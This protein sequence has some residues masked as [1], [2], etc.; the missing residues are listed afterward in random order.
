MLLLGILCTTQQAF[1]QGT[2]T[3]TG[4][5]KNSKSKETIA[6]VSVMVKGTNDGTFTDDKGNFKLLTLAKPPFTLIISSVGFANKEINVDAAGGAINVE[7]DASFSLG[8]DIVVAASRLPERILEAPVSIERVTSTQIRNIPGAGY[9][10]ALNNLKGVDVVTSSYTFK[11]VSTRGFN[12]SGNLRFN[13]FVDGMDNTAPA[14]NFSVS[15]IVGLT[16]LDVD[17][18]ELLS[19]PSSALYGSGGQNGTLLISSKDPFKYQGVSFMVKQ[20]VM[21]LGND[22][23]NDATLFQD[24]VLRWG[25]KIGD[26]FA[27]K[28]GAEFMKTDDWVADDRSNLARNNVLSNLKPGDRTSDPNY[29]GVNV[30][31]DE[32]SAS[33]QG[34]ALGGIFGPSNLSLPTV[35]GVLGINPTDGLDA[36]EQ[37][38]ILN[39]YAVQTDPSYGPLPLFA[40]GILTGAYLDDS[41]APIL[42][43]RT[44]YDE[45]DIVDYNAFNFKVSGGLYYKFT[46]TLTASLTG[47]WGNGTTV[48]T[49]ADRYSIK[50]FT[51]GQYRLELKDKNWFLRGYTTQENSGDSY[52]S[53]LAALGVNNAWSPNSTWFG[54]YAATYAGARLQGAD[55]ATSHAGA[56]GAADAPRYLPGS[57]QFKAAFDSII[58]TPI[59]QG[60]AQFADQ[61]DL[62]HF[63]GQ[64]NLSEAIKVVDVLIGANYRVFSLNSRGTIFADTA[65][66]I[67][68]GEY[69]GYI[70]LKKS[71]LNDVLNLT[72]SGR[73]DKNENFEGRFTPRFGASIKVAKDNNVRLSYQQ[74][75]RFPTNQDQ[76]INLQ[77]PGTVLIGGLPGFAE[78][79]NFSENPVFTAE[80]VGAARAAGNPALLQTAAFTPVRPEVVNTFEIGYR[81]LLSKNFL[82]DAYFYSSK[83]TDFIARVAVA[84]GISGNPATSPAEV[85]NPFTTTNYSFVTNSPDDVNATGWGISMEYRTNN[86]YSF[87]GN[88]YG[89]QLRNVKE[90]LVTF[91]N[92]PK[93]R[94]NLGLGNADVVGGFGFNMVYRWQDEVNWEGT[95]GSGAIPSFGV[96]DAAISYKLPKTKHQIKLGGQNLFNN[97][98]RNAFGN[99]YV[100]GLYYISFGYNVL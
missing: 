50:N 11:T 51:M 29:D 97:Y 61:S 58:T 14:L 71:I 59:S 62:W 73:Y 72:A 37:G 77:T 53:T 68:I 81:G 75:Y 90:G 1:T 99:P 74:A 40:N 69:G 34:V 92:T 46:N 16:E 48:Y 42:V 47:N 22:A 91:F 54:T 49:G 23:R 6:A 95:F 24:Y 96:F 63:E 4:N 39:F 17:N 33:M 31:G 12:G 20:G 3:V 28:I 94:F 70:Q 88:V 43:S 83:Y 9:Y 13:Q 93:L 65:G 82:V 87:Q 2:T 36:T 15:N 35:I 89:D 52:A 8:Q 79:Y 25:Q 7:L 27:F 86:G 38:Q 98:Y 41:G 60:G 19:G 30:L 66:R 100:G 26:K 21:H 18:M 84:R 32:A 80:S 56:R 78:Y 76:W 57:A 67:S 10:D 44:G 64:Y 85:L 5:V 45:Q 55:P